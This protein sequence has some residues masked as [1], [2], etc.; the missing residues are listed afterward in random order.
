MTEER[1]HLTALLKISRTMNSI[2]R[3]APL[4]ERIMDIALGSIGA[5][6]G[7]IILKD[8]NSEELQL[9]VRRNMTGEEASPEIS[10][11]IVQQAIS[12]GEPVLT[13]DAPGDP[14]FSSSDSV[15]LQNILSAACVPLVLRGRPIGAIYVDSK[16]AKSVFTEK[17]IR[18]LKAFADQAALALENAENHEAVISE[19]LL[20]KRQMAQVSDFEN[21]VGNSP[22]MQAVYHIM[23]SVI[24]MSCS[25]LIVGESGTGKELVA[26]AIHYK[27]PRKSSPFVAQQ[28]SAIPEQLL[29]SELFGYRRGA[30]TGAGSDRKG[31]FEAADN[32]TFLLDEVCD[33]PLPIQAKLLRVLQEGEIRRLGETSPRKVDVRL[34]SATNRDLKKEVSAGRFREDLYYRLNVVSISIPP[35]RERLD[36]I[37]LLANHFAKLYARK[38]GRSVERI[39]RE[40]IEKL[41]D[42]SW[43]GNV[44][45]LENTIERAVIM[46]RTTSIGPDD[47]LLDIDENSATSGKLRDFEKRIILRTLRKHDGNR[48]KTAKVLGISVRTLQY[49][50]RR[51]QEEKPR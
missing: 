16:S 9:K 42:H 13:H 37:P 29:E 51:W 8:P 26:R 5:E 23:K 36:D 17:T 41:K 33:I 28:C 44:R 15:I 19:N 22:S 3:T 38:C 20:L 18:F 45:E 11:S 14:R 10:G 25:V 46:C 31:L 50:L 49:K 48:T 47:L 12:S 2:M 34:I 24:P 40:A 32:G 30:F 4:L 35:L 6:R 43:P 7:F 27:G 1:D 21:I 39:E